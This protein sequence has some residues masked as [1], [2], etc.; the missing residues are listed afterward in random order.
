MFGIPGVAEPAHTRFGAGR[1]FLFF[2]FFTLSLLGCAS[3]SKPSIMAGTGPIAVVSVTS[4]RDINWEGEEET[5]EKSATN[6][7]RKATRASRDTTLVIKSSAEELINTAWGII[8]QELGVPGS[9][10]LAEQDL[11]LNSQA[12]LAAEEKKEYQTA[13]L[14][15]AE[16]YRFLDYRDKLFPPQLAAETGLGTLLFVDFA[17]TKIMGS[18]VGKNGRGRANV[19]MT[20]IGVNAQG[21]VIFR[22]SYVGS[23]Y[24]SIE[25]KAGMYSHSG[26]INLFEETLRGV[27]YDFAEDLGVR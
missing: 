10:G 9:P 23:S 8:R 14:V 13:D 12:Y 17:F 2:G 25:V 4:N 26:L 6:L 20:L 15:K 21:K 27:C 16:G 7:L 19:V 18:G 24:S 5:M 22:R 1:S 3:V 11:V